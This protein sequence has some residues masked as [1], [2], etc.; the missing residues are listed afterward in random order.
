MKKEKSIL[1]TIILGICIL[2]SLVLIGKMLLHRDVTQHSPY[3]NQV[4]DET[5][6]EQAVPEGEQ[7]GNPIY[8]SSTELKDI[9]YN[10]ISDTISMNDFYIEVKK[11]GTLTITGTIDKTEIEQFTSSS[12]IKTAIKWLPDDLDLE[13]VIIIDPE[14]ETYASL[15][16]MSINNISVPDEYM[17]T[18]QI[19]TAVYNAVSEFCNPE[20]LV[21]L[22]GGI[23][24]F[25]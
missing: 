17:P 15:V 14:A 19:N 20:N 13:A 2:S 12:A 25:E 5:D 11:D 7:I 4:V 3:I 21:M 10:K 24:Y 6:T 22:D 16:D 23:Q 1:Y 18:E 9:I 8:M